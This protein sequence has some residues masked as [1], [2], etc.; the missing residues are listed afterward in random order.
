MMLYDVAKYFTKKL[1]V[2]LLL[3]WK[4]C[5]KLSSKPFS[6]LV[7]GFTLLIVP[8]ITFAE[9]E[10][11]HTVKDTWDVRIGGGS[12]VTQLPWRGANTE[13]LFVPFVDVKYGR[14]HIGENG[15]DYRFFNYQNF[16]L[17]AGL[18]YQDASYESK[19]WMGAAESN[20][21][22]F[23]GYDSPGGDT[24][25]NVILNWKYFTAKISRDISNNSNG[26][27]AYFS[28]DIPITAFKSGLSF[29][30]KLQVDI[31][32]DKYASHLYGIEGNQVN[33]AVGRYQYLFEE[34]DISTNYLI[35]INARY[36]LFDSVEIL[37]SFSRQQLD[38]GIVN[39]PLN[40]HSTHNMA[41]LL[42][43]SQF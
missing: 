3:N 2:K 38:K 23:E 18:G 5:I 6:A 35:G 9:T 10:L 22:V 12:L 27:S 43:V 8:S 4:C 32:D 28:A 34:D 24:V 36:P 17:S 1:T 16:N 15:A 39:S 40:N 7:L 29:M 11:S 14:W 42:F 13:V 30:L 19:L 20:D 37:A 21:S 31:L 33:N 26:G 41:S 25:A